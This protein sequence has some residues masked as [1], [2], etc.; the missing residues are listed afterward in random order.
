[1][2]QVGLD[3]CRSHRTHGH[4]DSKPALPLHEILAVRLQRAP[5]EAFLQPE[6]IQTLRNRLERIHRLRRGMDA[7]AGLP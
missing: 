1:V 7:G 5:T 2:L 3:I 4:I 6:S